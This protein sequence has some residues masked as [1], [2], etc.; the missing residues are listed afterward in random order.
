[1]LACLVAEPVSGGLRDVRGLGFQ[2]QRVS[3]LCAARDL[4]REPAD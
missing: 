2:C 4:N 3:C 1:M